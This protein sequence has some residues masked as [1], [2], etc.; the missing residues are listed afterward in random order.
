MDMYIYIYIYKNQYEIRSINQNC[1]IRI[2][3]YECPTS[4]LVSVS[5][6]NNNKQIQCRSKANIQFILHVFEI[7]DVSLDNAI[8]ACDVS[9]RMLI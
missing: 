1:S 3:T 8:L 6:N 5:G 9:P 2:C 4:V 7:V